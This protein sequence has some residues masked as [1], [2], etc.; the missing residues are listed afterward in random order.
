MKE[1]LRWNL[2]S[3]DLKLS[4]IG[5]GC[6]QFSKGT[7][8]VGKY[9]DSLEDQTMKDIVETSIQGGINWFDTAEV[10]G[11]GASERALAAALDGLDVPFEEAIIATKWWPMLRKAD[12]IVKSIEI[13]KDALNQRPIELYQIHQPFSLSSVEK[14]MQAMSEIK[15]NNHIKHIGVSNFNEKAMRKAH[16]QLEREGLPLVSNQMKYSLLDRRL[17]RNGFL[18]A[19]KELDVA[20]IAYSPLE[21]G[22]LTGKFHDNPGQIKGSAGP[23]KWMGKF[24]EKGLAKTKPFI[25]LLKTYADKYGVTVSQVALNWMIHYHQGAMFV[26]PGASKTKQAEENA[27]AMSFQLNEQE[28]E[29]ISAASWEAQLYK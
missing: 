11:N 20:V 18:D 17:E 5:L 19:A 12:S 26:I 3:S 23:R 8:T 13:R 28:L 9:W 14:Q 4:P 6:W 10:Y 21:Q 25:E 22:L 7:N 15:K 1:T 29:D 24:K 16:K 27:G 2:G